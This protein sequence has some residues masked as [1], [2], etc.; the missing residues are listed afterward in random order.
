MKLL[1]IPTEVENDI[2][3]SINYSR[4]QLMMDLQM[5][6]K[7]LATQD[8][9]PSCKF[10]EN[11]NF[12]YSYLISCKGS[13]EMCK[14]K[15]DAYYTSRRKHLDSF[16]IIDPLKACITQCREYLDVFSLPQPTPDG[17]RISLVRLKNSS[18]EIY[19]F[20]ATIQ[21]MLLIMEHKLRMEGITNGDYYILDAKPGYTPAHILRIN[22]SVVK[23]TMIYLSNVLPWRVRGL[24]F[25]N[26]P[27]YV[28]IAVNTFFKPFLKKKIRE[29]ITVTEEGTTLLH[30]LFPAK[31]LP[32]DYGGE[33]PSCEE[34]TSAWMDKI[35]AERDW[36]LQHC[37]PTT[38]E[39]K[40]IENDCSNKNP[41]FGVHGSLKKLCI[42]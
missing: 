19:D 7:W 4:A 24:I 13:L 27:S 3:K 6:K 33:S 39:S 2:F 23:D 25:I 28:E 9:L 42:D 10:S 8:H 31:I 38:E 37:T 1:A 36:Y 35:E 32:K 22:A 30:R 41:I 40:R 26:A 16:G 11:D 15:I 18:L 14:K 29:R 12:F 34:L 21:V 20:L 17:S 5:L